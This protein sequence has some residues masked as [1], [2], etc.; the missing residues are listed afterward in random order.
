[1]DHGG[2]SCS[3]AR[4]FD[5][6]T[7]GVADIEVENGAFHGAR[8]TCRPVGWAELNAGVKAHTA[9][10]ETGGDPDNITIATAGTRIKF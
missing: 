5:T 8:Y 4:G 10:F 9:E 1:M 3:G 2:A 7:D 6:D